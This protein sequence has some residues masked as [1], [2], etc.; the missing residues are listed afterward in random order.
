M[1][2]FRTFPVVGVLSGLALFAW[3]PVLAETTSTQALPQLTVTA[4]G[5]YAA[6]ETTP[7]AVEAIASDEIR[8]HGYHTVGEALRGRPGLAVAD[9]GAQGQNPVVRGLKRES[10]VLLVDGM[11]LNS[12]QPAGAIASFMSLGL[13]ERVE[14]VKGPA[15]VLY[16]TGA[17]GGAINVLLPQA[18]FEPGIGFRAAASAESANQ[19]LRTTGVLN[20]STGDH[21]L[22]AGAS[23]AGIDDYRA[24][25]GT[26][27][28]SG[29]DANSVIGQYRFKLDAAQQIRLSLQQHRESDVWYPGSSQARPAPVNTLIVR[30]PEQQRTLTEIGYSRRGSGD[31]PVNLDL[32]VW[33]QEVQRLV[34]AHAIGTGINQSA[35][36]VTFATNGLDAKADW[37][38]HPN[39]LLSFGANTWQM[40]AAPERFVNGARNDPF[41]DGRIDAFGVYVQ[42]DMQ[43]GRLNL[44]A[45]LRH[46]IVK[47]GAAS[48]NNGAVTAGLN[49]RD[50]ATSGVLGAIWESDPLLRPYANLSRGFRAGEMRER[51]EA[52]PRADGF[53][54]RGAPQI[55]PEYANQ[56]EIGLKGS[57]EQFEYR[58][59]AYRTRI[60]DFITGRVLVGQFQSGLPVKQTENIG[61]VTLDGLELQGR[62]QALHKHWLSASLSAIRGTND[63]LNEP[64]FQMPADELT[65]SWEG[66]IAAGWNGDAALRLVRRQGRVATVFARGTENATPGF[67]TL[68]LGATY[69]WQRQSLR[70][71]LKNVADKAY[72]E[73]LTDGVSGQEIQAPGRSLLVTWQGSF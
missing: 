32:R 67:T 7:S 29:Y 16:G 10:I 61:R 44:L 27:R 37:L 40:R 39:H 66:A 9:D 42:D 73:H 8:A 48:M 15:S 64:M 65:L 21:A 50:S 34:Q 70:V 6:D 14:V 59:A 13:A 26:V 3:R 31:A 72:H 54:Y 51:F 41:S 36:D 57:S 58:V 1:P 62:W 5:Y 55:R 60:N 45:A 49:R 17:L 12:A 63:T 46:D 52:S 28:Y 11:R 2:Q 18:R 43:F 56:F 30:S 47:G 25:S 53:F 33:R 22:M 35:T 20:F 23:L 19:A 24:R 69:R 68:D 38:A 71:A 4:K